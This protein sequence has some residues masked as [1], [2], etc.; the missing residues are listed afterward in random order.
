MKQ[1]VSYGCVDPVVESASSAFPVCH[2]GHYKPGDFGIELVSQGEELRGLS[3]T[4]TDQTQLFT[5]FPVGD[6]GIEV[7]I[8][9]DSRSGFQIK[10]I[11]FGDFEC[12][13]CASGGEGDA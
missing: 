6:S 5:L 13:C 12:L 11:R 10:D 8:S 7:A 2:L 3:Q 9:S 4:E 1:V